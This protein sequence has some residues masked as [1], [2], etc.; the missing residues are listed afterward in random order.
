MANEINDIEKLRVLLGYWEN[1]NIEHISENIKWK[2]KARKAGLEEAA[3][4]LE[5]VIALSEKVNEHIQS[6]RQSLLKDHVHHDGSADTKHGH[7]AGHLHI[8]LHRIGVIRTPYTDEAPRQPVEKE[9]DDFILIVNEEYRE[10][11]KELDKFEF[12]YVLYYLDRVKPGSS[13]IVSPPFDRDV[14]VGVFSSRSPGRPNPVGLSIVRM[15]KIVENK[16]YITG[17]D[18]FDMTPLLDIKPYMEKLDCKAGAG[19]GWAGKTD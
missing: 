10:G 9:T 4:S 18:A 7:E 16:V 14:E 1:H 6:A 11:L 8:M 12:I 15:K 3:V 13:L 19:N 2:E 17:I 5:K